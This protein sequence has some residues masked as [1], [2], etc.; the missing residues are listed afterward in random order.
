MADEKSPKE[1]ASKAESR[2]RAAPRNQAQAEFDR[3]KTRVGAAARAAAPGGGFA[4]PPAF[5]IGAGAIPGWGG[6]PT[7]MVGSPWGGDAPYGGMG[8]PYGALTAPPPVPPDSLTERL[9]YT[10][11]LG[12]DVLNATLA[13]G[14]R[15]LGGVSEMAN[16][17]GGM[18][19]SQRGYGQGHGGC[20]CGHASCGCDDCC[21]SCCHPGVSS[22]GCDCCR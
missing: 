4:G 22:C 11:R 16:W 12:V 7:M 18:Y 3:Y 6:G 5:S 14:L 17:A 19:A 2:R 1:T 8:L 15:V 13:G 21:D 9:R 10:M 20:G